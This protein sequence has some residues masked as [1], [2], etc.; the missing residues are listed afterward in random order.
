MRSVAGRRFRRGLV[1]GRPLEGDR[2]RL[3]V[4]LGAALLLGVGRAAVVALRVVRVAQIALVVV[5][6]HRLA[7]VDDRRAQLARARVA[8]VERAVPLPLVWVLEHV[9]LAPRR[10]H[11]P[12]RVRPEGGPRAARVRHVRVAQHCEEVGPVPLRLQLDALA[13]VDVRLVV[14]ERLTDAQDGV[15]VVRL[16][17]SLGDG[18]GAVDVLAG[19]M[20]VVV[21]VELK[22]V[23]R[24]E[25][26]ALRRPVERVAA[27]NGGRAAAVGADSGEEE[28][29][30]L[31]GIRC[32]RHSRR[33]GVQLS[34]CPPRRA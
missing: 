6:G 28:K 33:D 30:H 24:E 29:P 18:G 14:D 19:A 34:A 22:V 11:V 8:R 10:P 23:L 21:E 7:P 16:D 26:R 15:R 17:D 13:L 31:R 4:V 5:V 12:D 3:R 27:P 1:L 25:G 2:A 32:V 20:V 9:H